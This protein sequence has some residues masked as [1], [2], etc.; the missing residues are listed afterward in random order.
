M[1]LTRVF[2]TAEGSGDLLAEIRHLVDDASGG[3][4]TDDDW[5]HTRGGW[6]VVV[7]TAVSSCRMPRSCPGSSMWRIDP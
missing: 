7:V 3:H 1:P 2:T 6:R 4:F 5:E